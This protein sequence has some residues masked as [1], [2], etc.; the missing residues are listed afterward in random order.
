VFRYAAAANDDVRT[1]AVTSLV[2]TLDHCLIAAPG[3]SA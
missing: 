2:K 3:H 1:Q